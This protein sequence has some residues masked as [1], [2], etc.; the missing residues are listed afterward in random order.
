[1][2]PNNDFSEVLVED[3]LRETA[4]RFFGIRKQLEDMI[5][6]FHQSVGELR[7]KAD[8]VVQRA[9][10][11]N[12]MLLHGKAAAGL[13]SALGLDAA[14][15]A[16]E[17]A[18]NAQSLPEKIPFSLS[19][20][21]KFNKFVL[22]AYAALRQECHEYMD[23]RYY[24]D[25]VSGLENITSHYQ[26]IKL[27]TT[28]INEQIEKTNRDMSPVCVLQ[29]AKQFNPEMASKE[30]ITGGGCCLGGDSAHGIDQKLAY[31]PI[32]FEALDLK[33]YPELP[34]LDQAKSVIIR[35]CRHL[36]DRNRKEIHDIV[37]D[38]HAKIKHRQQRNDEIES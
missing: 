12:F 20:Q 19:L 7:D 35:Y 32:D 34:P 17:S 8:R 4:T 14:L 23:G 10:L 36:V 18:F 25:P 6:T 15:F 38:L 13:Y 31:Q 22:E 30:R 37:T 27:M 26:Q 9:G 33:S 5:S 29:Y 11:L 28:I 24:T 2:N 21:H 1:M 16:E 3:F